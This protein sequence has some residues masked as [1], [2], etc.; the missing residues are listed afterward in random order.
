MSQQWKFHR[1][2]PQ[3]FPTLRIAQ[4]CALLHIT[5]RLL[6]ATIESTDLATL[7]KLFDCRPSEFWRSHF[8]FNS[9]SKQHSAKL[10]N[11]SI[12]NIL[13][14]TVVPFL[15]AYGKFHGDQDLI[16]KGVLF[17]EQLDPESNFIISNWASL[18]IKPYNAFE[19]QGLIHLY[20]KYCLQRK[21]MSCK[22]GIQIIKV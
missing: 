12:E 21:C 3:N 1:T 13:I 10:G 22:I 11:A 18:K 17:L 2:R 20:N 6:R 8:S 7:K 4:L 19:S 5:P 9:P 15:F 16:D 14:N